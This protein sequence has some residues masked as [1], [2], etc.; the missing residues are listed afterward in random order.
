MVKSEISY[1]KIAIAADHAGFAL[2]ERLRQKLSEEGHEVT[3]F[4]T[5]STESCDYPDYARRVAREVGQGRSDRGI[6]VCSTGIGMAM[7][8]NKVDGVRAAPA[9]SE[10][11]VRLTREHN[12]ANVLTLGARYLDEARASALIGIFL[13][14]EFS[15]GRHAR[16]VAKIEA[17]EGE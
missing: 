5:G 10:D 16:R 3:D 17:L 14:T 11:E 12:D 7:A 8:A 15:G 1:M 2:K 9:Q 6:L 13:G 4:G